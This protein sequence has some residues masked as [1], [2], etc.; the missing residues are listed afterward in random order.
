MPRVQ[1]DEATHVVVGQFPHEFR[2]RIW[3]SLCPAADNTPTYATYSLTVLVDLR[4]ADLPRDSVAL[5]GAV[6][7]HGAYAQV[8]AVKRCDS[9][10]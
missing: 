3:N 2:G 6:V 1:A 9:A 8:R 4:R 5:P 7:E 10:P